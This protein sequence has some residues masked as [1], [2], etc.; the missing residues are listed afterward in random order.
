VAPAILP[1]SNGI[2][3][4]PFT[5]L[6][7]DFRSTAAA[8]GDTG[9]SPATGERDPAGKTGGVSGGG[10]CAHPRG[11]HPVESSKVARQRNRAFI[12]IKSKS[13][14]FVQ[15]SRGK[16]NIY[17][18]GRPFS[19]IGWIPNQALP[20]SSGNQ[21]ARRA[22]GAQIP[23]LNALPAEIIHRHPA[24][25]PAARLDQSVRSRDGLPLFRRRGSRF[26]RARHGA[27]YRHRNS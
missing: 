15:A 23:V 6:V 2:T 25:S 24:G 8:G 16:H 5:R 21:L 3:S 7:R 19:W 9:F 20:R 17:L 26:L 11:A 4:R 12:R 27:F 14:R 13:V 18:T 1:P 10:V 22:G